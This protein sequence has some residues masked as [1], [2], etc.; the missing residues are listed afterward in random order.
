MKGN[1]ERERGGVWGGIWRFWRLERQRSS[2][3]IESNYS[4][5]RYLDFVSARRRLIRE[6][7]KAASGPHG[8][9]S[10]ESPAACSSSTAWS[11]SRCSVALFSVPLLAN[12]KH[13]VKHNT[14]KITKCDKPPKLKLQGQHGQLWCDLEDVFALREEQKL[15]FRT[16]QAKSSGSVVLEISESTEK[17]EKRVK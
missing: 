2:L 13:R 16:D 11:S 14:K 1:R 7:F 9:T 10:S 6:G 5:L 3:R 17:F 8:S 15:H 4:F 12:E